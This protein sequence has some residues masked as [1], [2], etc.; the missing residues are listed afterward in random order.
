[1]FWSLHLRLLYQRNSLTTVT[2]TQHTEGSV[3]IRWFQN[4]SLC[5]YYRTM[6][7]A[8]ITCHSL[9]IMLASKVKS[10]MLF[11]L[12]LAAISSQFVF[13][14]IIILPLQEASLFLPRGNKVCGKKNLNQEVYVVSHIIC[15]T[16]AADSFKIG[17]AESITLSSPPHTK[18][19]TSGKTILLNKQRAWEMFTI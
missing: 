16:T 13:L 4:N 2:P 1:M 5:V 17:E 11:V 18:Q 12:E 10:N 14:L 7:H 19:K 6:W 8:N 3:F 15:K 9:K